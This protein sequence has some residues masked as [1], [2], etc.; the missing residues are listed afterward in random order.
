MDNES[1]VVRSLRSPGIRITILVFSALLLINALAIWAIVSSGRTTR[2]VALD[3]LR[4]Q[5]MAHARSLEAV[6]ASRRADFLFLSQSPPVANAPALLAERDPVARRWGRLDVEASLLLFLGAHPEVENIVLRGSAQQP[7]IAVGRR[8]DAPVL[9]PANQFGLIQQKKADLRGAWPLGGPQRRSGML[10]VVLNVDNLLK[11]AAPGI[12]PDFSLQQQPSGAQPASQ[13]FPAVAASV[14]D[15]GWNP[16][17]DWTLVYRGNE[18]R[19]VQSVAMLAGRYRTIVTLNLVMISLALLVGAVAFRQVRRQLALEAESQRQALVRDFEKKLMESERLASVGRL[20]AGIAHEIN[21]PLEG[22][23][24]YLTLLEEDI[25]TGGTRESIEILEKVREGLDR[26]AGII[27][28]VLT[29]SDPGKAPQAPLNLN[30]ILEETVEFV[31][32]NPQFRHLA[33]SLQ[34]CDEQLRILGNRIALAQLFLN[35]LINACHVQPAG[36]QISVSSQG[37]CA[38][39]LVTVVDH[40]PGIPTDVLPHIFEPFYSTRG[41]TGLGLSVC[42][43]IV[44]QHRGQI[45]AENRPGGGASFEIRLPLTT[46]WVVLQDLATLSERI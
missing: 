31:R 5:T 3:E 11:L 20:A 6:L 37:D 16:P 32:S 36:G 42:Q 45:R 4:L 30:E 19:L 29:Y 9:M 33:V 38:W 27:R 40:G 39:A 8:Q 24:N 17:V 35:L 10:E 46:A 2:A 12:G 26:A 28:Q 23:S 13:D 25:R 34:P 22:M 18:S 43:G 7:I 44:S 14:R 1:R 21:N 41:S 15:D